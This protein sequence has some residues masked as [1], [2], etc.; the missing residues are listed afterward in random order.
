MK[1]FLQPDFDLCSGLRDKGFEDLLGNHGFTKKDEGPKT[2]G[3][4][5]KKTMAEEMDPIKLKVDIVFN[6][7]RMPSTFG[8]LRCFEGIAL[9]FHMLVCLSQKLN[10]GYKFANS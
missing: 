3:D 5:K 9:S 7:F 1:C 8:F 6:V 2:I 10:I 4:M